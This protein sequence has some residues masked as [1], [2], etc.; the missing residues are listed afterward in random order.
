LRIPKAACLDVPCP[1]VFFAGFVFRLL[2]GESV[3]PAIEFKVVARFGAKEIEVVLA[4][5]MLSSEFVSREASVSENGPEFFLGPS[6]FSA[7]SASQ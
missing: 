3:L 4:D 2:F 1:Q 7:Q 6:G 5:F